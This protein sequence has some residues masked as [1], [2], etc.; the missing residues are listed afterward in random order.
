MITTDDFPSSTVCYF[1]FKTG[2]ER[3]ERAADALS[4]ILHQLFQNTNLIPYGFASYKNH[5]ANLSQM[6]SDLWEILMECAKEPEVGRITCVIDALDECEEESRNHPVKELTRLFSSKSTDQRVDCSFKSIVTS[7]PCEDIKD[8]FEQLSGNRSYL[9]I[10]I[11]SYS[12]DLGRDIDLV[13]DR[14]VKDFARKVDSEKQKFI[15]DHLKSRDNRIYLWLVL[16]TDIIKKSS[17]DYSKFL[18]I[19]KL[20]F[21]L[22]EKFSDQ[23]NRILSRS[24]DP[25]LAKKTT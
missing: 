3:K 21:D 23:Y 22:R 9:H 5:G 19:K 17:I 1:F 8:Q 25:E 4:A 7:Q 11:D 18:N 20:L 16:T 12:T 10:D 2:Q 6:F 15:A 13:I 14:Q 24:K